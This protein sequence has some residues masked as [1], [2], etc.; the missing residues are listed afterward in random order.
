[1]NYKNHILYLH[2]LTLTFTMTIELPPW[3]QPE[4]IP[5]EF[6]FAKCHDKDNMNMPI[7]DYLKLPEKEASTRPVYYHF[8]KVT[9]RTKQYIALY[10]ILFFKENPGYTPGAPLITKAIGKH[11]GDVESIVLLLDPETHK[12][13][14]VYFSAHGKGQGMWLPFEKCEKAPDG[15]LR[16]YVAPA[17]NAM[18]PSPGF[19]ARFFGIA[20][21]VVSAKSAPWRPEPMDFLHSHKQQWSETHYQIEKGINNPK[22]LAD[23]PETSITNFERFMLAFPNIRKKLAKL[24]RMQSE[25]LF[26]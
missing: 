16:V 15:T 13:E 3:Q 1:M 11:P 7:S 25:L 19:Y 9:W 6:M 26:N 10:Y 18:Y 21:D 2:I 22:N 23:P 12:L 17:S 14:Q 20:N 8:K 4:L 24:P 5:V